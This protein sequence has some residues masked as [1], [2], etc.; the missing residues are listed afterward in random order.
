MES[1]CSAN[2]DLKKINVIVS[3]GASNCKLSRDLIVEESS[4]EHIIGYRCLSHLF[5]LIGASIS[6]HPSVEKH[7]D[8]VVEPINIIS[9]T[10]RLSR[11][12][13]KAGGGRT[14]R[15]NPTS[16]FSTCGAIKSVFWIGPIMENLPDRPEYAL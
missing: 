7:L 2:S 4:F 15:S 11:A 12:I 8:K 5:N 13:V 10:K 1:L 3:D 14:I 9:R 6:K 16:W